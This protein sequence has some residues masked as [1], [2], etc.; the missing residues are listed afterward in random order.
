MAYDAARG[1]LACF[2]G[3]T[4]HPDY[5]SER[6]DLYEL[7]VDG[8][9][10]W[11]ALQLCG[12]RAELGEGAA[13]LVDRRHQ[14]GIA[15]GNLNIR[16][17]EGLGAA[18]FTL[19]RTQ[20]WEGSLDVAPGQLMPPPRQYFAAV[21]DSVADAHGARDRRFRIEHAQHL[22]PLE[23]EKLAR[24][25]VL[26]SMQPY[27]A[28]DDGRVSFLEQEV[29]NLQRQMMSLTRRVDDLGARPSSATERLDP[30]RARALPDAPDQWLDAGK[31][32]QLKQ[33]MSELDVVSLL[34]PPTSMREVDGARV[35]FYALEIG[36]SGFLGGSVR[37]RERAVSEIRTPVLQ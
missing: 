3:R 12:H 28:A 32:R 4:D 23:I 31:W 18:R 13:I 15:I 33:G 14:Q 36:A 21:F 27:H 10:G 11:Q 35:L 5:D 8:P 17:V 25:G 6:N 20:D 26:A 1:R 19:G 30:P 24:S 37:F 9:D 2:G 29:R 34:G 16:G 7:D 22:R